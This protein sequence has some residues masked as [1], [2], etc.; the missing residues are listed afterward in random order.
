MAESMCW[1]P[2]FLV[3]AYALLVEYGR[4]QRRYRICSSGRLSSSHDDPRGQLDPV[5]VSEQ[6]T[7]GPDQAVR[8]VAP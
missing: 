2:T 4:A 6:R 7:P 5:R 3:V 8:A 1:W